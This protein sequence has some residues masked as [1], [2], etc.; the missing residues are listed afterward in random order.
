MTSAYDAMHDEDLPGFLCV[1]TQFWD[2]AQPDVEVFIRRRT[3]DGNWM[4]I[5]S[6]AVS[7]VSQPITGITLEE[8]VVWDEQLARRLNRITRITAILIQAVEAARLAEK[9]P[10]A[11]PANG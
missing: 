3:T 5:V 10:P 1:K 9:P 7:Y 11:E 4:S 8:S 2:K 6:K